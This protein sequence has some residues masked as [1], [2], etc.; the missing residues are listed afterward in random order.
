M[1]KLKAIE[2]FLAVA[3]TN[4]FRA[5]AKKLNVSPPTVTR[6][7]NELEMDLGVKLIKRTTR[8][9]SLTD[10]GKR[11]F[12]D[13]HEILLSLSAAEQS[14]KSAYGSLSGKLKITAPIMFGHLY[15]AEVICDFLREYPNITVDAI[16]KDSLFEF[17][18]GGIDISIRIGEF[19]DTSLIY[20]PIGKVSWVVCG[21][22]EYLKKNGFPKKPED[23]YSHETIN[24]KVNDSEYK[25]KFRG[26]I[27]FSSK[28]RLAFNTISALK[29]AA[30]SNFGLIQVLSYQVREEFEQGTLCP[31]LED[32]QP[33]PISVQ[34]AHAESRQTSAKIRAFTDFAANKL[35]LKTLQ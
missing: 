2:T 7:I 33:E 20:T 22:P 12:E 29:K 24:L 23:L 8:Q 28:A 13:C 15:V 18:D 35:K 31:I 25:W 34:I 14:V 30:R 11:F 26:N 6:L 10:T 4:G 32:F 9:F 21:S 17:L 3:E 19:T 1:D 16:Y 27:R 5:A